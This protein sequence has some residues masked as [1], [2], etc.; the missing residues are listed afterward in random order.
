[1]YSFSFSSV[2]LILSLVVNGT[3]VPDINSALPVNGMSSA[4]KLEVPINFPLAKNWY[5][6]TGTVTVFSPKFLIRNVF[7]KLI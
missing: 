2:R 1:M 4:E 6:I 5:E 7:F 3:S